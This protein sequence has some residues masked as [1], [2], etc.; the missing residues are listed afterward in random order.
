M[1]TIWQGITLIQG[2]DHGESCLNGIIFC[3]RL[4]EVCNSTNN[5]IMNIDMSKA[6]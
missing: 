1:I 4:S 5:Q 3:N 6:P 2:I